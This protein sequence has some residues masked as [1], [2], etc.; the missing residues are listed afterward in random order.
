MSAKTSVTVSPHPSCLIVVCVGVEGSRGKDSGKQGDGIAVGQY[1]PAEG[2][3]GG[4]ASGEKRETGREGQN[5]GRR[6]EVGG[7]GITGGQEG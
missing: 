1:R 3:G 2:K 7:S 4:A 5:G 6:V